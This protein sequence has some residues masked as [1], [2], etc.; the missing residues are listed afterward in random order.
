MRRAIVGNLVG[1]KSVMLLVLALAIFV[2]AGPA[3]AQDLLFKTL[4]I[5]YYK[6]GA[7]TNRSA[8]PGPNGT[9]G[10]A[11]DIGVSPGVDGVWA[12]GDDNAASAPIVSASAILCASNTLANGDGKYYVW[13]FNADGKIDTSKK[14]ASFLTYKMKRPIMANVTKGEQLFMA[15]II[16]GVTPEDVTALRNGPESPDTNGTM[17]AIIDMV[18]ADFSAGLFANNTPSAFFQN[19]HPTYATTTLDIRGSIYPSADGG[20]I[21]TTAVVV[22]WDIAG[23]AVSA[24]DAACA[25][26]SY[27]ATMAIWG[28]RTGKSNFLGVETGINS[29]PVFL[30]D[31]AKKGQL[32]ADWQSDLSDT[33]KR[34]AVPGVDMGIRIENQID[35][36]SNALFGL[37]G[38][39]PEHDPAA[40]IGKQV[41]S[42]VEENV[43]FQFRSKDQMEVE[44]QIDARETLD[45]EPNEYFGSGSDPVQVTENDGSSSITG[46]KFIGGKLSMSGWMTRDLTN[47]FSTI[48]YKNLAAAGAANGANLSTVVSVTAAVSDKAITSSTYQPFIVKAVI[49]DEVGS[50]TEA[51]TNHA[52]DTAAPLLTDVRA[53]AERGTSILSFGDIGYRNTTRDEAIFGVEID[54]NGESYFTPNIAQWLELQ[55]RDIGRFAAWFETGAGSPTRYNTIFGGAAGVLDD[56]PLYNIKDIATTNVALATQVIGGR[57]KNIPG[58]QFI[59][60]AS[61]VIRVKTNVSTSMNSGGLIFC[62]SDDAR[63]PVVVYYSGSPSTPN[64]YVDT[65]RPYVSYIDF[66]H[67]IYSTIASATI[68]VDNEPPQ[69]LAASLGVTGLPSGYWNAGDPASAFDYFRLNCEESRSNAAVNSVKSVVRGTAK[70]ASQGGSPL[71]L[72]VKFRPVGN[73]AIASEDLDGRPFVAVNAAQ[74][75][76][77]FNERFSMD[78][79]NAVLGYVTNGLGVNVFAADISKTSWKV[80]D[81]TII[82]NPDSAHPLYPNKAWLAANSIG[83]VTFVEPVG[84]PTTDQNYNNAKMNLGFGDSVFNFY[85]SATAVADPAYLGMVIDTVKPAIAL[86]NSVYY[87]PAA[88]GAAPNYVV[89]GNFDGTFTPPDVLGNNDAAKTALY[90]VNYNNGTAIPSSQFGNSI[91][92]FAQTIDATP[93]AFYNSPSVANGTSPL[94]KAGYSIII[95]ASF[96]EPGVGNDLFRQIGDGSGGLN[97]SGFPFLFGKVDTTDDR[98]VAL[99]P[100]AVADWTF[101]AAGTLYGRAFK[102]ITANF[103]DFVDEDY[104]KDVLPDA[105]AVINGSNLAQVYQNS[106]MAAPGDITVATWFFYVDNTKSLKVLPS[107]MVRDV[108]FTARDLSGNVTRTGVAV[109]RANF[110]QPAVTILDFEID[111]PVKGIRRAVVQRDSSYLGGAGVAAVSLSQATMNVSSASIMVVAKIG[112]GVTKGGP[113]IGANFISAGFEPFG[114]GVTYPNQVTNAAGVVITNGALVSPSDILYATWWVGPFNPSNTSKDTAGQATAK[115]VVTA[116]SASM[117]VGKSPSSTGVQVD[118]IVPNVVVGPIVEKTAL[119]SANTHPAGDQNGDNVVRPNQIVS[120]P[121]EFVMDQAD[122]YRPSLVQF[123]PDLSEFGNATPLIYTWLKPDSNNPVVRGATIQFT[124]PM[125]QTSN[126]FKAIA[127][128]TDAAGNF[129]RDETPL[130]QVNA[131]RPQV[132]AIVLSA[133]SMI[134]YATDIAGA[135]LQW[136]DIGYRHKNLG[137]S[138]PVINEATGI[139]KAGDALKVIAEININDSIFSDLLVYADFSQYSGPAYAAVPPMP[140]SSPDGDTILQGTKVAGNIYYATWVHYLKPSSQH[141]VDASVRI[142]ARNMAGVQAT[143]S[144]M[145]YSVPLTVDNQGPVVT[146]D[147]RYY[148]NGAPI[149]GEINP[150][151]LAVS[152][153]RAT[154]EIVVSA[155]YEDAGDHFGYAGG[156]FSALWFGPRN[157]NVDDKVTQDAVFKLYDQGAAETSNPQAA[158]FALSD[159]SGVFNEQGSDSDGIVVSSATPI[160]AANQAI[161]KGGTHSVL[162][163]WWGKDPSKEFGNSIVASPTAV[164]FKQNIG[165]TGYKIVAS[166]SDVVGNVSNASLTDGVELDGLAPEISRGRNTGEAGAAIGHATLDVSPGQTEYVNYVPAQYTAGGVLQ[167]PTRV[168]EGTFVRLSTHLF[169]KPDTS[170][171]ILFSVDGKEFVSKASNFVVISPTADQRT[172]VAVSGEY[173]WM[174]KIDPTLFPDNVIDV[175]VD[176]PIGRGKTTNGNAGTTIPLRTASV[177]DAADSP[178]GGVYPAGGYNDLLNNRINAPSIGDLA[179]VALDATDTVN[180]WTADK[181]ARL[182]LEVDTQ[183]PGVIEEYTTFF[184]TKEEAD[185]LSTGPVVKPAGINARA[186][187]YLVWAATLVVDGTH[188]R[189]FPL[190]ADKFFI[191][192]HAKFEKDTDRLEPD[193]QFSGKKYMIASATRSIVFVTNIIK[194]KD[195]ADP[196]S[197]VQVFYTMQDLFGNKTNGTS[198]SIIAISSQGPIA[199][200]VSLKVGDKTE[201]IVGANKLG[202]GN[203]GPDA[204]G[205]KFEMYPGA[206]VVVEATVTTMNGE[207]PDTILA[208]LSDLYPA[209]LKTMT[210]ELIPSFTQLTKNGTVYVK[211]EYT[212]FDST[213]VLDCMVPARN[214]IPRS[215]TRVF[216]DQ[217]NLNWLVKNYAYEPGSYVV[218]AETNSQ[219]IQNAGGLVFNAPIPG[220]TP[221]NAVDL[222]G[223]AI[224]GAPAK[225]AMAGNGGPRNNGWLGNQA[226]LNALQ[227]LP[228]IMLQKDATAK[229]VAWV[230]VFVADKDSLYKAERSYSSAF[231]IDTEPPRAGIVYSVTQSLP[232]KERVRPVP[233]VANL[234][235]GFPTAPNADRNDIFKPAPRVRQDDS[236]AVIIQVTNAS[237]DRTGNDAFRLLPGLLPSDLSTGF[238]RIDAANDASIKDMTADLSGFSSLPGA[239]NI[240]VF[241]PNAPVADPAY[242][243]ILTIDSQGVGLPD[244]ITATYTI[245][246]SPDLGTSVQMS[247]DPV[248][249]TPTVVDDAGNRPLDTAYDPG[250]RSDYYDPAWI[251][252]RAHPQ[253]VLAVDNTGPFISGSVQAQILSGTG[254]VD[255]PVTGNRDILLAGDMLQDESIVAAGTVL[256]VTVTVTDLVDHPLD[257]I[258]KQNNYGEMKLFAEGM[259]LA[260][261]RLVAEDAKLSGLN[262]IAVPF[263]VTLPPKETGKSTFSFHFIIQATDTVGNM[264]SKISTE[265]FAFDANPDAQYYDVNGQLV[266]NG[267]VVTVNASDSEQKILST[268]AIDVGGITNVE[269][270]TAGNPNVTFSAKDAGGNPV[271]MNFAAGNAQRVIIDL[272][273]NIPI[274]DAGIDPF[275]VKATATDI[276]G[277]P[278]EESIVTFNINQ[279]PILA[280]NFPFSATDDSVINTLGTLTE[281]TGVG[282]NAAFADIREV[283]ISEGTKVTVDI[284]AIDVNA[285]DAVTIDVTGTAVTSPNIKEGVVVDR[286]QGHLCFDFD[287]GYLACVGE[288]LSATFELDVR[289]LDGTTI[290]PDTAKL[291][292]NVLAKSATPLVWVE[293]IRINENLI[294]NYEPDSLVQLNEGSTIEIV[295]GGRDPGNEKLTAILE[296]IPDK[297]IAVTE[298]VFAAG[299]TIVYGT[300]TLATTLLDADVPELGYDSPVDPFIANF[301]VANASFSNSKLVPVDIIN[302]SQAPI[303]SATAVVGIEEPKALKNNEILRVKPGAQVFVNF[304]AV[305]P[306]GDAVLTTL[307][308]VVTAADSFS[309]SYTTISI[310]KAS[311]ESMLTIIVPDAVSPEDATATVVY[312]ASD[313]T[314]KERTFTFQIVVSE[315]EAPTTTPIE[316]LI[317]AQGVGGTNTVNLKNID[318]NKVK[319]GDK[320]V[321]VNSTYRAV[322][323]ASGAFLEKIGGGA[324]REAY[325]RT[326]DV[327]GDGD[328]DLVLSMGSV[329]LPDATFPN[330]VVAKD[331]KTRTLIGNSFVAF[332]KGTGDVNYEGGDIPIAVGNFIGSTTA[333]QIAT[334]QGFG[335]HNIIRIYQYTGQPAPLGFAVVAQ[336]NGLAGA[337]LTNN[338]NGGLSLGAGDLTGDGVDELIVGQTNSDTSRT[339]F[340]VI[341]LDSKGTVISRA[342]GVAFQGRKFQGNG[343]V[344]I[345]VADLNNDGANELVFASSG[346]TQDFEVD[347]DR[348]SVAINLVS[349]QTPIVDNG[350]VKS[351][352]VVK[353]YIRNAFF[354]TVN[355]SGSQS[356]AT[357]E[358]NGKLDGD[359]MVV[360]TNTVLNIEGTTIT[361]NKPAP[362]PVYWIM[363]VN[364]T[365]TAVT[366]LST[367]L[368]EAN[369]GINAFAPAWAPTSGAINVSS[370]LID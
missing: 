364:F 312:T 279:P 276:D 148:K 206:P 145:L 226:A 267:D 59:Q 216:A 85:D 178:V 274:V 165:A 353:G 52:L 5:D 78:I 199:T 281:I 263:Q 246:V 255:N 293:S 309:V 176:F 166:V 217:S 368:G 9:W 66:Q 155:T 278:S 249:V 269:W 95:S 28:S 88:A 147:L 314:L 220:V 26:Q 284:N 49:Q 208:D 182:G 128:A 221:V 271:D 337:A 39:N 20:A 47:V 192:W 359:E 55:F 40:F 251:V 53:G 252:E 168:S 244:L 101:D 110:A 161:L 344:R 228:F 67:N 32:A 193:K 79:A 141:V 106:S 136:R 236:V 154:A 240:S 150:N 295:F 294:H 355:P 198:T 27:S 173:V 321:A 153:G 361:F 205:V 211:W 318:P 224:N 16:E 42:G 65:T 324:D 332:Q 29:A 266:V 265:M 8:T 243:N 257:L 288:T 341:S 174:T 33:F 175:V 25:A 230:T 58:D 282:Y 112:D 162:T 204:A 126:Y 36:T 277:N 86:N 54:P 346:N 94:L 114:G 330:I 138:N 237:I 188:D 56:S 342:P 92:S 164:V 317:V 139:V 83:Y 50:A 338:A 247:N 285:A 157:L 48:R 275:T 300:F 305:D 149:T 180:N 68:E 35:T 76:A 125:D 326:G 304:K 97:N 231:S 160:T 352:A 4:P 229:K 362:Y 308:P 306:D 115:F 283:T 17:K 61:V 232:V 209:G 360:G 261:S 23:F 196:H 96:T 190:D 163:M 81:A 366:G 200:E 320:N 72:V 108:T 351:C 77:G 62:A 291:V 122:K 311:F 292:F 179:S 222:N 102:T 140:Y 127:Y 134:N 290:L 339:Q 116:T 268:N 350:V 354:A 121:V 21:S 75:I 103:S 260:Q 214:E 347:T 207:I 142:I 331:A 181:Y 233:G 124:V 328:L 131:S 334:A 235:I 253:A 239:D 186:G 264:A 256:R 6:F 172:D 37:W 301:A 13:D 250:V 38:A 357:I 45:G 191:D 120:F 143:E 152:P 135:I 210:D 329:T 87:D 201:T 187:N 137:E 159:K 84:L 238:F 273:A 2:G 1:V 241:D 158:L 109:G 315:G 325:V 248:E 64:A 177:A 280:A 60:G 322:A 93:T 297:V 151:S 113:F 80:E 254:M 234:R 223:A 170:D 14:P 183:G 323:V 91:Y 146:G 242:P 287:P 316:Q 171:E 69:I 289:A 270:I 51:Y 34:G 82:C 22:F 89:D 197:A 262:S 367:V 369:K 184:P 63:N 219:T 227:G 119:D 296:G 335:G 319:I 129:D 185:L 195:D 31:W 203:K 105:T 133:S 167:R 299:G 71:R 169:D 57:I 348:N 365:G 43:P 15:A 213:N 11:D 117:G 310:G 18:T 286:A 370:G 7:S 90:I 336:F 333:D 194:I 298:T 46:G 132:N 215:A 225:A 130:I 70:S 123:A 302:V 24:T 41:Y 303:I 340:T 74:R 44:L 313:N 272:F 356:I 100:T 258:I 363:K 104:A 73:T 189:D 111:N 343:G 99:S 327:D 19:I 30:T 144:K 212:A 345:A 3:P 349:V 218:G 156:L 98:W 307:D 259:K 107:N 10:D 118:H 12:T 245:K 202:I 358:A